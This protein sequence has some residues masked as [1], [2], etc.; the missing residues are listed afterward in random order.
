[1]NPGPILIIR[2]TFPMLARVFKNSSLIKSEN[3]T[4][5]LLFCNHI[6]NPKTPLPYCFSCITALLYFAASYLLY[7][8]C[9]LFSLTYTLVP[10][11][12][13]VELGMQDKEIVFPI[14]W[15]E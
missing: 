9:Y 2:N 7:C 3:T 15:R 8:I 6:K 13:S 10:D 1:M 5:Y 14:A 11:N 12:H 4:T